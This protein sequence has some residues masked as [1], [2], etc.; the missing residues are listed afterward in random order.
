[1]KKLTVALAAAASV[2]LVASGASAFCGFYVSGSNDDLYNNATRVALMRDGERTVLSMQNNYEGPAEDFAMVVPVPVV[3]KKEEVKTLEDNVFARLDRLTAPRLVEYWERDPCFKPPAVTEDELQERVPDHP[4]RRSTD[5]RG[6]QKPKVKVEAKFKVGE[7]DIV[8]L[9]STESTALEDW[10]NQNDY[11]IPDGA[12]PYFK[13]YIQKG[14][15]F[16][17]ARV[18]MDKVQYKDGE[19]ILSPIRFHYDSDDFVL[20]VRLGLINSKGSQDLI[21]FILAKNNRYEV[22][23]LPNVT[24]P[25]NIPVKEETKQDFAG[26]Y[27]QLFDNVL[28]ENPQAVVTEYAWQFVFQGRKCDPCPPEPPGPPAQFRSLGADVLPSSGQQPQQ[29]PGRGMRRRMPVQ[30]SSNWVIT[31]LHTRYGKHTLG[32]DLVFQPAEP[33]VG[34]NGMP[35]GAEGTFANKGAKKASANRFQGRYI[36]RH[37][38]DGAVDCENPRRGVWGGPGGQGQPQTGAADNLGFSESGETKTLATYVDG[39]EKIPGLQMSVASYDSPAGDVIASWGKLVEPPT[40]EDDK[41]GSDNGKGGD[42]SGSKGDNDTGSKKT[43][44]CA[45]FWAG[46]SSAAILLFGLLGMR[47]AR[48]RFDD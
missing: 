26:F 27:T 45:S 3:L 14:Q 18:N 6:P 42:G 17:V 4:S 5:A 20:P 33:I 15:Y 37:F 29:P 39:R 9:S 31:R 10:L 28:K 21:A 34:G 7:Y 38:W 47:V 19:A 25:T 32:E 44:G 11:N 36:I 12:A 8:V 35:Q 24:I 46:G 30:Q 1:M 40:I 22:A 41:D 2:L 48:R 23:N 13:P 16:F 43:G